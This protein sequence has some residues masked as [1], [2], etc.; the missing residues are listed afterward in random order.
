ML[1]EKFSD[2]IE[3]SPIGISVAKRRKLIEETDPHRIYVEN[4]RS[5]FNIPKSAAVY[6]CNVAVRQGVFE[7]HIG[8][9]CP[10]DDC[11]SMLADVPARSN[12]PDELQCFNCEALEREPYV[13]NSKDCRI[14]EFYS[15][16]SLKDAIDKPKKSA[17]SRKP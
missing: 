10:N 1:L 15:L 3:Q 11:H 6:L 9:L 8:Y 12:P 5:F 13:F 4:I 2:I 17:R 14:I 16:A 7:K